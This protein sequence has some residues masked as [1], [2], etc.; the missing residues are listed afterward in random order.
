M[1][2]RDVF[3]IGMPT[4]VDELIQLL[5]NDCYMVRSY[6]GQRTESQ[7]LRRRQAIR[8]LVATLQYAFNETDDYETIIGEVLDGLRPLDRPPF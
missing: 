1:H 2:A 7:R 8:K 5:R 6:E 3:T 4:D